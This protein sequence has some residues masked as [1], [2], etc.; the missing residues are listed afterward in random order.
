MQQNVVKVLK[1]MRKR[2]AKQHGRW[3]QQPSKQHC[4]QQQTAPQL[5]WGAI[6]Q[7]ACT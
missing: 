5:R 7:Q 6:Q 3:L 4:A 1:Y 2:D